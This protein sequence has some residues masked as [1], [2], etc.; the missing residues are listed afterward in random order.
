MIKYAAGFKYQICENYY[1][2]TGI[3]PKDYIEAPW[4]GLSTDGILLIKKGFASD[5][6]S[7]WVTI[8]TKTFMRG[9]FV[10]DALYYLIKQEKL[11]LTYRKQA[12]KELHR[13]ILD[14]GMNRMRAWY[15][16]KAVQLFGKSAAQDKK[17]VY[18]AP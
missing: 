7:G 16:L 11:S 17:K 2:E 10:H 8:H 14:D 15:V 5:G 13:I 4:A 12:D 9:A 3:R 18:T 1:V 6:P